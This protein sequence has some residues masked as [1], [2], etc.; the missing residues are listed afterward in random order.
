MFLQ[1]QDNSPGQAAGLETFFD[2]IVAIGN[3]RLV[4][5][6][7][8]DFLYEIFQ[9]KDNDQLKELLRQNVEKP[10]ELTVYNSKTQT[11]RQTQITPSE[12]WG[13]QGLLGVSIRFCSFE[14]ANQNVWHIIAVQP[15]S[16][17]AL[18]GLESNNDYVLGAESVL[19]Q[20][21]DLIALV[22]A[23]IGKPLKLYVYNVVTDQVREV[24]LTPNENW[25][26][27]GCLGCDI[28][29][30]YLHRIPVSVDRSMPPSAASPPSV[31][32]SE[33]P[34]GS[35]VRIPQPGS[36]GIPEIDSVP[37]VNAAKKFPDPSEFL[38]PHVGAN[39]IGQN[40]ASS[41]A[42]GLPPPPPPVSSFQPPPVASYQPPP[43]SSYQPPPVS[44][45]QSPPVSSYQPPA[46]SSY[47][48][49]PISKPYQPEDSA[50]ISSASPNP[51]AHDHGHHDHSHGDHHDHHDHDHH[52]D[53]SHDHHDHHHDHEAS[54]LQQY[55]PPPQQPQQY[56]YQKPFVPATQASPVPPLPTSSNY[57][58]QQPG[59]NGQQPETTVPQYSP[60][61]QSST[62]QPFLPYGAPPG[63][64]VTSSFSP[65][66]QQFQQQYYPPPP[67]FRK[68]LFLCF[69]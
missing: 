28:G 38:V 31:V 36:T 9:D 51:P 8:L 30:G 11:V 68:F 45:Y 13:G 7:F 19:N 67:T 61:L 64:N 21:D 34:S 4:R 5:Y 50:P 27:E 33:Y 63:T 18:A 44:S 54:P 1:V 58:P 37:Q 26:G 55:Q 46:V 40:L 52:H 62:Y 15:N 57:Y 25:G 42:N 23:N 29:Y 48:P 16:P 20:A 12:H 69:I 6:Y 2:Y 60:P 66:P 39:G 35:P 65:V 59:Q 14:G 53:H 47:Q 32:S 10:V 3:T 22:Q 43:V 41:T 17:A 24:I 49:P 56:E